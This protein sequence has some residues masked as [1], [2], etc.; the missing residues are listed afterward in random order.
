M[1]NNKLYFADK[2]QMTKYKI[3]VVTDNVS[4]ML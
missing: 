4:C 1:H 3:I 2:D